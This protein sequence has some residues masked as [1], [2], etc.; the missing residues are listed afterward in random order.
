MGLSLDMD[1]TLAAK[2]GRTRGA[3]SGLTSGSILVVVPA[4]GA[5][6]LTIAD[7]IA[8]RTLKFLSCFLRSDLA[9]FGA[10]LK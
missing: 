5:N 9:A 7:S 3:E 1:E 10:F 4:V 6:S 8:G 2:A